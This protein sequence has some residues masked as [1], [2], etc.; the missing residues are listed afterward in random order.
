MRIGVKHFDP[1]LYPVF[2][3]L[4][5]FLINANISELMNK[6]VVL[7]LV[8]MPHRGGIVAIS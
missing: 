1:P 7:G 8:P 4:Q 5:A 3:A 6:R 2:G